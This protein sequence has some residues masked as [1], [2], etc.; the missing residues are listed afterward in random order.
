MNTSFAG[1]R[2]VLAGSPFNTPPVEVTGDHYAIHD[3][4]SHDRFGLGTVVHVEGQTA[5][6]ADFGHGV[7]R[8][9]TLPSS[10][11]NKL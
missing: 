10:K 11:L 2:R 8:R 4:V 6:H 1:S 9:I 5:V 3:R 7:V